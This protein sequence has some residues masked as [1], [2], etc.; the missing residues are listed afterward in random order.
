MFFMTTSDHVTFLSFLL[1]ADIQMQR[2]LSSVFLLSYWKILT[3][4]CFIPGRGKRSD[5]KSE[6]PRSEHQG[7]R[8]AE[9]RGHAH[10]PNCVSKG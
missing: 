1:Q 3:A 4:T 8:G 7:Y 2:V 5:I 6:C 10:L 9:R